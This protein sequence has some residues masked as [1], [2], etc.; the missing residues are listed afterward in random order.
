MW[1]HPTSIVEHD[2]SIGTG[3]K[4]WHWSHIMPGAVIGTNCNIGNNVSIGANV[5]IGNNV[6]IQNNAFIPEGVVIHDNVFIGPS[7]VFTNVF[8]PRAIRKQDYVKT[9]V[10]QG[11]TIGANA[12]IICGITLGAYCFVGAGS[13]VTKDIE[14]FVLAYGNPAKV[15]GMISQQGKILCRI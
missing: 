13:V 3:T 2:V 8:C 4:I 11:A 6:K 15:R 7:V 1:I 12:T 5:K 10:Q 9:F 14:D